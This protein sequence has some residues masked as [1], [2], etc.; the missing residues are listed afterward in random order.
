MRMF[1]TFG[2]MRV[3][4]S[5]LIIRRGLLGDDRVGFERGEHNTLHT[6]EFIF[7]SLKYC[8]IIK[9]AVVIKKILLSYLTR[10]K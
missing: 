7:D 1:L 6:K 4:L 8:G 9:F 5:Q 3:R 10:N 2:E